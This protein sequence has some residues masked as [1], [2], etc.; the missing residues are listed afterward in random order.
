MLLFWP[1]VIPFATAVL[2]LLAW[3]SLPLQRM[4]SL[5][6]ALALLAVAVRIAVQVAQDGTFAQQAGGWP[7]PF[8]ITM[9]AD[10][11]SAT[12]VLLPGWSQ[13]R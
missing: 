6:G 9:V 5:A 7:A 11:L 10:G 4:I 8:G 13:S 12:M 2:T 1:L 3:R